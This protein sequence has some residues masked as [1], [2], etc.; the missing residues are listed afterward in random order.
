MA[1]NEII[2][3]CVNLRQKYTD[4][5]KVTKDW[6]DLL[7][8]VDDN[9]QSDMESFVGN[10]PRTQYNM[11]LYLLRP[12]PVILTVKSLD[13]S[14][15]EEEAA[16]AARDIELYF[17][18]QWDEIDK[19]NTRRGGASWFRQFIGMLLATGWYALPYY[20]DGSGNAK[21]WY[22][23]YWNPMQVYPEFADDPADERDALVKCARIVPVDINDARRKIV[24]YGWNQLINTGIRTGK[25]IE[26]HLWKLLPDGTVTHSVAVGNDEVKPETPMSGD[27]IP[28]LVGAAGGLPDNGAVDTQWAKSWGQSILAV[29]E[30][31]F[32]NLNRQMTFMQ[33]LLHD[34]ANPRT[35]EKSSGPTPLVTPDNWFKRGAHYRLGQNDE[36]GVLQS[37]GMPVELRQL[38]FD[39]M[40]MRQRGGFSDLVFGN[41]M[42]EISSVIVSQAADA[43]M[44]LLEPF[45][46][47]V[48]FAL[49][50]VTN[51]WYQQT[52]VT[53]SIR[54][55]DFVFPPTLKQ[56]RMVASYNISIPGDLAHRANQAKF[57]N[58]DFKLSTT[59]L[60][61]AFFPEVYNREREQ[62]MQRKEVAEKHPAMALLN[63]LDAFEREAERAR[64]AGNTQLEKRFTSLAT[65]V[66]TTIVQS[67]GGEP[68]ASPEEVLGR[69]RGEAR[70]QQGEVA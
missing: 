35:Y 55:K 27:R 8:L 18:Q 56:T 20:I 7:K 5:T 2:K 69:V 30:Q 63:L 12:R 51:F 22:V 14:G 21:P 9:E 32:A 62:A 40:G 16:A 11:A 60:M 36:I 23:Q 17:A 68:Q 53:E 42:Q 61:E 44:Q 29:N 45:Y 67:V 54:P 1:A 39:L 6:Y 52:L 47:A 19:Q 70:Q 38:V 58:P 10:D 33:Q 41:V 43:A 48:K 24:R 50:E 4:R 31:V 37:P 66:E 28:I 57:L 65:M 34:T 15:L 26:Y 3:E 59:Y 25:V 64:I 46:D 49:S 13:G